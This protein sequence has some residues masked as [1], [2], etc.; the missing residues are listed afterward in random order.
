MSSEA[1]KRAGAEIAAHQARVNAARR[2][3]Y[4]DRLAHAGLWSCPLLKT[5]DEINAYEEGVAMAELAMGFVEVDRK[6]KRKHGSTHPAGLP[7]D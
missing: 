3:G 1:N 5:T 7:H 6:L 2:R 4:D